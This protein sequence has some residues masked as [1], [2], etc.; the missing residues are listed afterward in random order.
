MVVAS[1][2]EWPR[3]SGMGTR[4]GP[5]DTMMVTALSLAA[6]EPAGGEVPT[7]EPDWTV[8]LKSSRL[9]G[10]RPRLWS[11]LVAASKVC[12]LRSGTVL[13]RGPSDT[14]T[15]TSLPLGWSPPRGDQ[16]RTAPLTASSLYWPCTLGL[17]PA[18]WTAFT[19]ASLVRLVRSGTAL[20]AGPLETTRVTVRCS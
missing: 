10:T 4:S 16:S 15:V 20:G 8:S 6:D 12:A 11:D 17:R 13:G 1:S 7:T 18:P 19:A 2:T 3:T 14:V 5:L 9:W